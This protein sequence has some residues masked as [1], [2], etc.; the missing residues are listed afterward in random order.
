[1]ASRPPHNCGESN[2]NDLLLIGSVIAF[3]V[4]GGLYARFCEKL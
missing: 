1:M 2:M 3:F 4:I